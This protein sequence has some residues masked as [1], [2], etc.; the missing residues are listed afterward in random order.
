MSL[1]HANKPVVCKVHGF[2][3]AGGTD[4]ALC[5][6]LLVIADDAKIGYPPARV[7]GVPTT[8]VWALPHRHREGEAPAVHRRLPVRH[9]RRSSGGSRPS[10]RRADEL[11]ERFEIAARA[12][13]AH[14]DQPARDDEA[15]GQPDRAGAGPARRRRSSAR[16]S[17]A[18]PATPPRATRSSSAPPRSASSRR[19]ASATSRSATSARRR[20]RADRDQRGSA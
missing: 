15:A 13:R 17:T 9:A 4:M 8:A 16:C 10:A 7:W 2:C 3:V 12:H 11:D 20:S 14:A 1:F 19:C 18:S 5:C 6:D